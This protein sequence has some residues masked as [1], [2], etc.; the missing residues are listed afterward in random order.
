M[1]RSVSKEQEAEEQDSSMYIKYKSVSYWYRVY[2][3]K[4]NLTLL[5]IFICPGN[6]SINPR[7]VLRQLLTTSTYNHRYDR[8]S[9]RVSGK[10]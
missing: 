4:Y 3:L 2:I 6:G 5:L 10:N 8:T 7:A 9:G 1:I